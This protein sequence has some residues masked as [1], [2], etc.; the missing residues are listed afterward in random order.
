M[1]TGKKCHQLALKCCVHSFIFVHV[2]FAACKNINNI[3]L[4]QLVD[5]Q[6]D[7]QLWTIG[8]LDRK[9]D[10]CEPSIDNSIF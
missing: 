2:K 4:E 7:I 5:A 10:F 8:L 6:L 3:L 1:Q 9:S